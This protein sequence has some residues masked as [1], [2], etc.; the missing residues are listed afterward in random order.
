M[1]AGTL[2]Q[3]GKAAGSPA[4]AAT[5]A[6]RC[7]AGPTRHLPDKTTSLGAARA[8]G[9][10]PA[11]SVHGGGGWTWGRDPAEEAGSSKRQA[12]P[13]LALRLRRGNTLCFRSLKPTRFTNT[14]LAL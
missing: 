3:L 12:L 13:G 1:P 9:T 14:Q 8:G 2:P 4:L 10:E 7:R 5:R 6:L 11:P